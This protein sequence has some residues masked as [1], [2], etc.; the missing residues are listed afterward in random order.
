MNDTNTIISPRTVVSE[1]VD[2][3]NVDAEIIDPEVV[4]L[5]V[6]DAHGVIFNTPLTGF[7]HDLGE[8]TGEGGVD[9]IARW[10]SEIREPFWNGSLDETTMWQLVAPALPPDEL[11]R[12]LECRYEPGPLFDLVADW[13]NDLWILSNHRTNWLAAR[14]ARFGITEHFDKII[15][16]D[17]VGSSKPRPAAFDEVTVASSERRVLFIDDQFKNVSASRRLGVPAAVVTNVTAPKSAT[18]SR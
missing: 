12:D 11:R 9:L 7:L 14:L 13:P 6:L 1:N 17:S 18:P 2:T 3:E 4:D 8:M 15:V 10:R 5:L 16:S